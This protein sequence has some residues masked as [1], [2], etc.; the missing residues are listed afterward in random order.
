MFA[1]IGGV[2]VG[3]GDHPSTTEL[4]SHVNMPVAGKHSTTICTSGLQA[5]VAAYLPD[6]P[7]RK[8]DIVDMACAYDDPFSQKTCLLGLAMPCLYQLC[9]II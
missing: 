5:E 1:T 9:G 2:E 6:L 7:S 4:D 8:I 3:Y